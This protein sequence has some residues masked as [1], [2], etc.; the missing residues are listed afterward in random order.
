MKLGRFYEEPEF[1]VQ[2][3]RRLYNKCYEKCR[4]CYK[5]MRINSN[6]RIIGNDH[7]A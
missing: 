5:E 1:C 4:Q 3:E 7:N 6:E 2:C